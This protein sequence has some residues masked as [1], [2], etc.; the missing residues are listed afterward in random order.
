MALLRSSTH[1]RLVSRAYRDA[2]DSHVTSFDFTAL[3]PATIV[4]A[5]TRALPRFRN[6]SSLTLTPHSTDRALEPLWATYLACPAPLTT[7]RISNCD[8]LSNIAPALTASSP[9][10][11]ALHVATA[12][13]HA[14]ASILSAAAHHGSVTTV[15]ALLDDVD[16]RVLAFPS[17]C[18]LRALYR[19]GLSAPSLSRL[20]ASLC[21]APS[22]RVVEL[23]VHGGSGATVASLP[24][25][26]HLVKLSLFG[27]DGDVG[28]GA[29]AAC[30]F[31]AEVQLEWVDGLCDGDIEEFTRMMGSRLVRLRIWNCCG[32]TNAAL[33]AVAHAC[34]DVEFD[35]KFER[36]QF[37]EAAVKALRRVRWEAWGG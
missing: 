7:L 35:L 28:L 14:T 15:D 1:L 12:H 29:L 23:R 6:L 3:T 25:V 21:Q 11:G 36:G 31:L 2:F 30:R 33:A 16:V 9:R 19:S 37:S 13:P 18:V 26:P 22:L 17:L 27:V 24:S 20:A 4:A 5:L 8:P 34:P 10:L 32:L